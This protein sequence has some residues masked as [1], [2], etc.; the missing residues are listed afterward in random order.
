MPTPAD[1]AVRANGVRSRRPWAWHRMAPELCLF[2]ACGI[3]GDA[4]GGVIVA[5]AGEEG[6]VTAGDAGQIVVDGGFELLDQMGEADADAAG[7]ADVIRAI[8]RLGD[9]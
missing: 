1:R 2:R 6:P 3:S 7:Q 5:F 9:A 8:D 4:A